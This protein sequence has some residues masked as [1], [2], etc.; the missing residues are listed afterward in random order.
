MSCPDGWF[1]PLKKWLKATS[2]K[3]AAEAKVDMCPPIPG[4][5]LFAFA[6]IAIAFHLT[7]VFIFLSISLSP[8]YSGC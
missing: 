7:I 2:Y 5:S 8:G 1:G 4:F 6:T 3:V